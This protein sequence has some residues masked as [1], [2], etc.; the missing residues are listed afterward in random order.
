MTGLILGG[1][2]SDMEFS[3][4]DGRFLRAIC[5]DSRTNVDI[6]PPIAIKGF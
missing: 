6:W 3:V 5:A 2:L 1:T 4:N